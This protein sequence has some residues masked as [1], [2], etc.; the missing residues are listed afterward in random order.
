MTYVIVGNSAASVAAVESIRMYDKT[1]KIQVISDEPHHVY[2]RPQ[3]TYLLGEKV[4]AD[5][6]DFR[7]K[8]FYEKNMVEA[9][10][11]K[12]VEN[13]DFSKKQLIL[14]DNTELSYDKLLIATGGT[15]FVPPIKGVKTGNVHTFTKWADVTKIRKSIEDRENPN[16]VVIGAGMIGLKAV[17]G[18]INIGIKP[19]VVELAS[20]VLSLAL[21]E[22]GSKLMGDHL[23]SLGVRTICKNTVDEVVSKGGKVKELVLQD[24]SKVPCDILIVAIGV[25]PNISLVKESG[26]RLGRGIV[27]NEQMESSV[28]GVYSAGDVAEA[29]DVLM[30][31]KRVLPIWPNAIEQGKVAGANMAGHKAE[32]KGGFG[33][34][35]IEVCGLS[36]ISVGLANVSGEEYES[37]SKLDEKKKTYKKIVMRKDGKIV[38][39]SFVKDVETAGIFKK[40]IEEERD[41]LPFKNNLLDDNFGYLSFPEDVRKEKLRI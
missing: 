1:G 29:Y 15:P 19:T 9:I 3:I 27:V 16:V 13:I 12:C 7:P 32:F 21:D 28:D 26:M 6:M 39:A 41:V 14:D 40:L 38:G 22:V 24:G 35:S 33:M 37:I 36:T 8:D 17:E 5:K 4:S 23:E 20:R 31:N 34:N 18:F 25:V 2:S 11:G 10:L 30:E